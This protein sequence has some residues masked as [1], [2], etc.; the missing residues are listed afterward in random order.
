M[1]GLVTL[2][3]VYIFMAGAFFGRF[4]GTIPTL[5]I[6]GVLLYVADPSLF[7][8]EGFNYVKDNVANYLK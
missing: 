8:R 5:M 2:P 1:S 6:S 4:T 3:N 7:T